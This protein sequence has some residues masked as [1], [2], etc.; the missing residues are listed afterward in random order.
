MS[1]CSFQYLIDLGGG[2]LKRELADEGVGAGIQGGGSWEVKGW[3]LGD[4]GGRKIV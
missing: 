1:A 4:R 3:D 2:Q